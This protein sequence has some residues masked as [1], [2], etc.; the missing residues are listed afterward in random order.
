MAKLETPSRSATLRKRGVSRSSGQTKIKS[1]LILPALSIANRGE[2]HPATQ[3]DG[4]ITVGP[5]SIDLILHQGD[6]CR[7]HNVDA[8]GERR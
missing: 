8:I 3:R 2:I 1:R 4:N 6:Q 7:D 5:Q